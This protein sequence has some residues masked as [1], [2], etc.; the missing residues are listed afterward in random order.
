MELNVYFNIA[1]I[2]SASLRETRLSSLVSLTG[3]SAG[4]VYVVE[5]NESSHLKQFNDAFMQFKGDGGGGPA[6]RKFFQKTYR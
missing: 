1:E 3:G 6:V 5:D 4:G 2:M